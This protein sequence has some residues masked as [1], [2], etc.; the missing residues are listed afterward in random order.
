MFRNKTIAVLFAGLCL[1]L[2][3]SFTAL[4][5]PAFSGFWTQDAAGGW[6]VRD[7]NGALVKNA[8]L[9]DDAV[10]ANGKDVWYLID[11]NGDMICAGLVQDGTGNYYS[12]ETNHNGYFGMLRCRSGNYSADGFDVSL[13]LE[14]S[15]N[16]SFAAIR[17]AEGIRK[18]QERYGVKKVTIDNASCVYTSSFAKPAQAGG[19]E[20]TAQAETG[21]TAGGLTAADFTVTG[22][23]APAADMIA[24]LSGR[25]THDGAVCYYFDSSADAG[26]E[27]VVKTA[28]NITLASYKSDVTAA[29]GNGI[30][31]DVSVPAD[32]KAVR[33]VNAYDPNGVEKFLR[34]C[35][36]YRTDDGKY[37]IYFGFKDSGQVSYIIYYIV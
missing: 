14:S 21:Q 12:L 29:Y 35:L 2:L 31:V 20:G 33:I 13:E 11:E 9:C 34:S 26:R 27:G 4:A 3:F 15:H 8:W 28:R 16:G 17:N 25:Y 10:A 7:G 18:L 23:S 24:F 1:G 6:H 36:C 19:K 37:A 32:T 22:S 5:D 30:P